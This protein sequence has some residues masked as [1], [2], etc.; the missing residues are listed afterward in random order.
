MF[1]R[2]ALLL[3]GHM[4][5]YKQCIDNLREVILSKYD[6]DVYIHTWDTTSELKDVKTDSEEIIALYKANGAKNV[7]IQI[8]DFD[9]FMATNPLY[10]K[11]RY[12]VDRIPAMYIKLFRAN[13]MKKKIE[14]ENGF[15]YDVC[16]RHRPDVLLKCSFDFNNHRDALCMVRV[17]NP[18]EYCIQD[19]KFFF[20]PSHR[21]DQFCE[22][23]N[24]LDNIVVPGFDITPIKH[25]HNI[26][27]WYCAYRGIP[28]EYHYLESQ[29]TEIVR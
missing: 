24:D 28:F 5:T 7:F 13:E 3:S 21:M 6:V 9:L 27:H 25:P 20:G 16:I 14:A 15:K 26:A 8:D 29:T 4:R 2:L 1:S 11:Y 22:I 19:D 18:C 23:I 12:I 10:L 17:D